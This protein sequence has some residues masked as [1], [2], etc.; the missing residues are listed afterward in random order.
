MRAAL[1]RPVVRA[2]VPS[3][4]ERKPHAHDQTAHRCLIGAALVLSGCGGSSDAQPE[5][6]SQSG[7]YAGKTPKDVYDTTRKQAAEAAS[8]RIKGDLVEGSDK[9]VMDLRI[10]RAG[11]V[12]GSLSMGSQGSLKLLVV[13]GTGFMLPG[14]DMLKT[15]SGGDAEVLK[16]LDGKWMELGQ[17]ADSQGIMDLADMDELSKMVLEPTGG[18]VTFVTGKEFDGRKTVGLEEQGSD[19]IIYVAADAPPNWSRS[20]RP[21]ATSPGRTG[22][23]RSG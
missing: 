14:K 5:G 23:S 18:E 11:N 9:V 3:R 20:R 21:T 17:D 1:P 12:S 2:S 22:T 15:L 7:P 4:H 6:A 10:A 13:D 19:S 8:V 16:Y